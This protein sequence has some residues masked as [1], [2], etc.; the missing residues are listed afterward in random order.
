V[1]SRLRLLPREFVANTLDLTFG[2]SATA[3]VNNLIRAKSSQFGGPCEY[4]RGD[5][6]AA[7]ES[8][9]PQV[10]VGT[11]GRYGYMTRA[12]DQITLVDVGVLFAVRLAVQDPTLLAVNV[13]PPD[14][15]AIEATFQLFY[16]D[17]SSSSEVAAELAA[18]IRDAAVYGAFEQWRYLLLTLCLSPGWQIL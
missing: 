7:G 14:A 6:S 10:P 1:E 5:C 8:Q 11:S 3:T 13:T 4:Y 15:A 12:C 18:L 2:P 16:Q 9:L 17:R